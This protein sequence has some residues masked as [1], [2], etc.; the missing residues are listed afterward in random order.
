MGKEIR[1]T[2]SNRSLR[3]KNVEKIF[4]GALERDYGGVGCPSAKQPIVRTI[5][6]ACQLSNKA[7]EKPPFLDGLGA[8]LHYRANK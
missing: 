7:K 1:K 8:T 3:A 6:V 5:G 2:I 4:A